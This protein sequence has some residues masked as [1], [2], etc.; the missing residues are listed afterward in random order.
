M[1]EFLWQTYHRLIAETNTPVKRFLYDELLKPHRLTG[2]IG[3][4]GVGKTTLMLQFIKNES[5]ADGKSFYFSADNI[6]FN[7]S[8]ILAFVH[9]LYTQQ[10]IRHFYIDEIHQYANWNQELKNIHDAFPD[11]RVI[12]SGSSSIDL[13]EGSYDLS[14]RARLLQLPGLSFREYLNIKTGASFQPLSLEGLLANHIPLAL[15]YTKDL[16]VLAHFDE[17]L[18]YGYYPFVFES[19]EMLYPALAQV[20]EKTI[21]E[22]IANFYSLKTSSLNQFKRILNFL[23]SMPP[24]KISTNNLATKLGIDNKTTDHYLGI[25]RRTGLIKMLFPVAHG[26]Q[27]L[28]KP[29]KIYV[30]NSTLLAAINTFLAADL[31]KGTLRELFFLQSLQTSPIKVFYPDAG[32][33][34]IDQ[35]RFEIGGRNKDWRQYRNKERPN[36][37]VK[38]NLLVGTSDT[39]PLYLFG[40]LY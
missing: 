37:L 27:L 28:S 39:I 29:S 7:Q 11:A 6:Y 25:L 4:R 33:F 15:S 1:N 14:R 22:D 40:F 23:A 8:S 3:P 38:D 9:D 34:Q 18:Q 13:V 35:L 10:Q 32:D 17:Y 24:G 26:H 31:D 20:I 16:P 21:H 5:Y 30:D 2:I 12:F 19:R 36:Y